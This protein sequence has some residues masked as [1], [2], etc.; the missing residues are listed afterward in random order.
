MLLIFY[1]IGGRAE[2]MNDHLII[3]GALNSV[4]FVNYED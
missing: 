3:G 4:K 1:A 2:Q